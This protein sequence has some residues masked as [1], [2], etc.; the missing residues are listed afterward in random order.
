MKKFILVLL[1]IATASVAV[2]A[3]PVNTASTLETEM[4]EVSGGTPLDLGQFIPGPKEPW[5]SF[6]FINIGVFGDSW[7]G[8][9]FVIDCRDGAGMSRIELESMTT[10]EK[11]NIRVRYMGPVRVDVN[12]PEGWWKLTVKDLE[13]VSYYGTFHVDP[14][15]FTV[16]KQ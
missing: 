12:H 6:D 2:M 1:S 10:G 9:Y 4:L 13:G 3:N 16:Y 7:S 15:T 5:A 14:F 11:K 8:Y